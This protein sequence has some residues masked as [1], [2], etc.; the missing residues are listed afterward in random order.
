M[1]KELELFVVKNYDDGSVMLTYLTDNAEKCYQLLNL[2]DSLDCDEVD[3]NGLRI[4]DD[5]QSYFE[6]Q[7]KKQNIYIKRIYIGAVYDY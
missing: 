4:K 3:E 7:C 1:E 5:W 2:I 6:E